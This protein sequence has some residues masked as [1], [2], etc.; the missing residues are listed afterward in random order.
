[1]MLSGQNGGT[2]PL[3]YALVGQTAGAV[4]WHL[5]HEGTPREPPE[6]ASD[7]AG[8]ARWAVSTVIGQAVGEIYR[9]ADDGTPAET[10]T[11]ESLVPAGMPPSAAAGLA[12]FRGRTIMLYATGDMY[13]SARLWLIDVGSG[14]TW[15]IDIAE[16]NGA[17]EGHLLSLDDALL[18]VSPAID[19]ESKLAVASFDPESGTLGSPHV[20]G[21]FASLVGEEPRM[22]RTARG[23]AV[24]WAHFGANAQRVSVLLQSFDCCT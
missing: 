5:P 2:A 4:Q 15:P 17:R 10:T 13:T 6:H 20:L 1:L 12:S 19:P 11:I 3:E 21:D 23:F 8:V 9:V 7:D 16:S 24:V 18:V 14:Q 22:T